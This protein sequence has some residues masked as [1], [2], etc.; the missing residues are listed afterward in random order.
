MKILLLAGNTIRSN[1]YAQYLVSNSFKIE[2]LFY[3][4]HEIEYEAPQLNYETKHFF[5]KSDLMLPDLEMGIEKVFDNHGQKYH[6]VEE[7]DVNSKNIIN[8]IQAM[9]PDLVIFSGYGGQILK[10]ELFDLNIP[11]LHMHPGD[12][13]SEKGSTTIYYSIL[14]RKSCTVTAFL[15]N[16]KIDA[17]D[18][19]SKRNYC[20]PTRNVN[21]DQY[22]DNII[23][24]NCLIDALNAIS[25]K[26][27]IV[28]F[29]LKD[30]SLEYYIIHPVLKNLSILS[31][32]NL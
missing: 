31:L 1:S 15:M 3:G 6:H 9:G 7:H 2:G 17:G 8:Q 19:I 10:K 11:Y 21:I 24:A 26:K 30:R 13:P 20:A 28:S 12:I 18:I 5:I 25:Q 14:N 29:P 4:F 16:E 32:D 27:D 23:R 22:Y